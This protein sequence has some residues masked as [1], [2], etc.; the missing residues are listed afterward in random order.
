MPTRLTAALMDKIPVPID[1]GI[2]PV[3]YNCNQLVIL[4][5]GVVSKSL[6]LTTEN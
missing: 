2:T 4:F 1:A 3:Y 5:V 6:V